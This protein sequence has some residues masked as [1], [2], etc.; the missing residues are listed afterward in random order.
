MA[1]ST[2]HRT[3]VSLAPRHSSGSCRTTAELGSPRN[4]L[5]PGGNQLPEA[6]LCAPFWPKTRKGRWEMRRRGT[7]RD[8]AGCNGNGD[9]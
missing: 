6:P 8:A 9:R 4:P 7:N 1:Q 3:L 5:V 2:W